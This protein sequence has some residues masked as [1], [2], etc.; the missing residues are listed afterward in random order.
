MKLNPDVNAKNGLTKEYAIK[1]LIGILAFLKVNVI[2]H[3][4]LRN[5]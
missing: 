3:V 1:N 2:N 4:M 5:I